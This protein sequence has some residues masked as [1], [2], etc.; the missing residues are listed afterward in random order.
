MVLACFVFMV[1]CC[2]AEAGG[3]KRMGGPVSFKLKGPSNVRRMKI[4][5]LKRVSI[6]GFKIRAGV[7]RMRQRNPRVRYRVGDGLRRM[8]KK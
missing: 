6:S 4:T 5:K 3:V 2:S 8:R 7:L 1:L